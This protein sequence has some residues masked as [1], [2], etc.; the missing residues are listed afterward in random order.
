MSATRSTTD[1]RAV[2]KRTGTFARLLGAYCEGIA[3]Y[4]LRRAAMTSLRELDDRALRDIGLMRYQIKAA[5]CGFV[6]RSD[7]WRM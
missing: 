3:R 1:Q 5:V 7:Q 2:T 4:F 6:A